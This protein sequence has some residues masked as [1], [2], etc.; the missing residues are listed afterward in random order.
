MYNVE[1]HVATW[2]CICIT[3]PPVLAP[4]VHGARSGGPHTPRHSV[5]LDWLEEG[6]GGRVLLVLLLTRARLQHSLSEV[7]RVRGHLQ[8]WG[9]QAGY[10]T[11]LYCTVLYCTGEYRWSVQ[12]SDVLFITD[13]QAVGW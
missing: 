9:V 7:W 1:L 2:Y 3:A 5:L 10:C 12:M 8:H 11:A 4:S 6:G 13:S